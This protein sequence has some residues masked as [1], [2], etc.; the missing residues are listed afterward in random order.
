VRGGIG[1]VD[2]AGG[3]DDGGGGEDL[4]HV[5]SLVPD[6]DPILSG[7][8]LMYIERPMEESNLRHTRGAGRHGS[9]TDPLV[10]VPAY[11]TRPYWV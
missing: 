4:D 7:R 6:Y 11:Q 9:T 5:R 8:E 2:D 10:P 3:G 1:Q